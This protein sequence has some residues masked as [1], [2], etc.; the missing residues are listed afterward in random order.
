MFVDVEE[1]VL[2]ILS[3]MVNTVGGFQKVF[4]LDLMETPG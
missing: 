2:G 4:G 3:P 1:P